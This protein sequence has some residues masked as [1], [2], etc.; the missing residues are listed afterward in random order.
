MLAPK[1][2]MG[3]GVSEA[4]AMQVREMR[5]QGVPAVVGCRESDGHYADV[6]ATR[7]AADPGAV[8]DFASMNGATILIAHGSPYFEVLPA[9]TGPFRTIAYEYG[10]PTPELFGAE[11]AARR[12]VADWKRE[13]V[14][15]NVDRVAAISKFIRTDIRWPHAQVI[16]LGIEHV[17]D[18]GPKPKRPARKLLRVG[19]LMRLGRGEARYKGHDELVQLTILVP[20][21]SWELAGRGT[22]ADARRL[23]S[24]GIV[25]RLNPTDAQR[26]AFLREID[27]FVTTSLWEGTNLP[28]VEAQALGTPGLAFDTAAHPEFTPFVFDSVDAMARRLQEYQDR[29]ELIAEDGAASYEFVRSRMSWPRNVEQLIALC[30]GA[31]LAPPPPRHRVRRELARFRRAARAVAAEGAVTWTR[32]QVRRRRS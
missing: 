32:E 9:L 1:M 7:V 5:A 4:V 10:D 14:Y 3:H 17:P 11:A 22:S 25:T 2:N 23:Q 30:H 6:P 29:W 16:P 20:D 21:V 13:A 28:L 12:K 26:S 31:P 8:A 19:A 24:A 18:L 27:V 15:P